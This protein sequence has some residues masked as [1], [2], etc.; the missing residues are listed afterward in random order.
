MLKEFKEFALKGNMMDLR[1]ISAMYT[2]SVVLKEM[3][4]IMRAK[5]RVL[6]GGNANSIVDELLF[7]L[8]EEK[9]KCLR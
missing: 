6:G 5:K 3:P 8:L 2:P 1:E 7:S 4:V 9:A